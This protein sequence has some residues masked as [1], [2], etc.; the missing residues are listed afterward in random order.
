MHLWMI[1]EEE[2]QHDRHSCV[3]RN[4]DERL[5]CHGRISS[6][7]MSMQIHLA[8]KSGSVMMV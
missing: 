8:F 5:E 6:V 3:G 1:R 2:G 7:F 4:R